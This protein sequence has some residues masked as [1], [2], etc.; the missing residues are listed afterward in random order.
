MR[1][2]LECLRPNLAADDDRLLSSICQFDLLACWPGSAMG[3]A[4]G[5]PFYPN[6]ARYSAHRSEPAVRMLLDDASARAALAADDDQGL[7]DVLRA[8]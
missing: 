2:T 8:R 7:A 5:P 1:E 4:S 6:F 3:R